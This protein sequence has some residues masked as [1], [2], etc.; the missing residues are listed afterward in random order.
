MTRVDHIITRLEQ[1]FS[2][3]HLEL[4]DDSQDHVGHAGSSEGAGHYTLIISADAFI[5]K[6]P[7]KRHQM[8]YEILGDMIGP[9]IH[10]LR[11]Q[12]SATQSA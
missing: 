6:S 9:E 4:I 12:A 5:G 8:I 3:S 7:V 2:P 1:A 11:I 10:A